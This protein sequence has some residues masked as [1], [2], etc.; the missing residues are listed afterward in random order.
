MKLC[1]LVTQ[2]WE[3]ADTDFMRDALVSYY[4][5]PL[6]A[7][8]VTRTYSDCGAP[9][10]R[11]RLMQLSPPPPSPPF[12]N[13]TNST[14]STNSSVVNTTAAPFPPPPGPVAWARGISLDVVIQTSSN[15]SAQQ[16]QQLFVSAAM[17]S[18]VAAALTAQ[19][20][21][22]AVPNAS[23]VLSVADVSVVTVLAPPSAPSAPPA[24]PSRVGGS[25]LAPLSLCV[26][27]LMLVVCG[28]SMRRCVARLRARLPKKT[29]A[30]W[31]ECELL[32]GDDF[33]AS[34]SWVRGV[35]G[36]ARRAASQSQP[37]LPRPV[38]LRVE[39]ALQ[40]VLGKAVGTTSVQLTMCA[41]VWSDDAGP[42]MLRICGNAH[43]SG[44]GSGM[45][46]ACDRASDFQD[47]LS[48]AQTMSGYSHTPL[49]AT[50]TEAMQLD[51]LSR[52]VHNV[53]L[54]PVVHANDLAASDVPE[55]YIA[56]I[57]SQTVARRIAMLEVASDGHDADKPTRLHALLARKSTDKIPAMFF[58]SAEQYAQPQPRS[59][60]ASAPMAIRALVGVREA[61]VFTDEPAAMAIRAL[62]GV[63]EPRI[64]SAEQHVQPRSSDAS[65]PMAIR[66]LVG[67]RE[68][69]VFT[70]E[71]A[72]M[73]IRA[74]SGVAEPRISIFDSSMRPIR[75]LRPVGGASVR[76]SW[77]AGS[78]G[79]IPATP[80]DSSFTSDGSAGDMERGEGAGQQDLR[81]RSTLTGRR[82]SAP[83]GERS[84]S[85]GRSDSP[86]VK[87]PWR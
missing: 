41:V 21:Q 39:A 71:P 8:T 5:I 29:V 66:A 2:D 70:D 4:G 23:M 42:R 48:E 53:R 1:V 10:G 59:S 72:A 62:S 18:S 25:R 69:P 13:G 87:P 20:F 79:M 56:A 44:L 57:S 54:W 27:V 80:M 47:C 50:V 24:P 60:H 76:R 61:P 81:G 68:A 40:R 15:S 65:A 64:S 77:H 11:R 38:Q 34:K 49:A 7:L 35:Y 63:A 82:R 86:L 58:S 45:E 46:E 43:F 83:A 51:P 26:L 14:N 55:E 22:N 73:A 85:G 52:G 37:R 9:P 32:L 6:A 36:A 3:V 16:V 12:G 74:L 78:G 28:P 19:L 84:R 30:F 67:V 17:N 31:A 75:T 33:Y